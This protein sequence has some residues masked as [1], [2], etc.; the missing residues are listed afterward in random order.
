MAYYASMKEAVR[1]L[2]CLVAIT[3]ACAG[4]TTSEVR[5]VPAFFHASDIS[6]QPPFPF[7]VQ[8]AASSNFHLFDLE[9]PDAGLIKQ[10]WQEITRHSE[11]EAT[12]P[13]PAAAKALR[14]YALSQDG[15]T[16]IVPSELIVE[17][18]YPTD[19]EIK[20]NGPP[21]FSGSLLARPANRVVLQDV[22][23]VAISA[24]AI[25]FDITRV[26][27][28]EAGSP[29]ILQRKVEKDVVYVLRDDQG[30]EREVARRASNLPGLQKVFLFT[31]SGGTTQYLF[32]RWKPDADCAAGCCEFAYA[33]YR[34]E[35]D[36]LVPVQENYYGCDV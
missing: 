17:I 28:A 33:L 8:E 30:N 35:K 13:I 25:K 34:V 23:A 31:Y 22:G 36:K 10:H 9:K 24:K 27:P 21:V 4:Q 5:F 20:V 29:S 12:A 19:A 16:E 14:Y 11:F 2:L 15:I 7:D 3:Y 18:S 1:L 26:G 6:F 32:V